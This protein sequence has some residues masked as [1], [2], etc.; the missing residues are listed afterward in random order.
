MRMLR[1]LLF[2]A[3]FIGAAN[4]AAEVKATDVNLKVRCQSS[5]GNAVVKIKGMKLYVQSYGNFPSNR[6]YYSDRSKIPGDNRWQRAWYR[7]GVVDVAVVDRAIF[8]GRDGQ[9][10]YSYQDIFSDRTS[11]KTVSLSCN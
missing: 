4:A 9:I 3:G 10:S 2:C 8:Q 11:A 6:L 5:V 1:A 7:G